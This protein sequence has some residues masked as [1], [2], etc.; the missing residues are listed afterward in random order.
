MSK[1]RTILVGTALAGS[2]AA[3]LAAAPAQAATAG[4]ATSAEQV[5]GPKKHFFGPYYSKFG[6]GESFGK[7]S[8]FKGYWYKDDGR[9]WFFGDLFDRDRDREY[10]YVW[11]KWHDRFGHHVKYYKTFG[12][13]HFDK[14]GGFKGSNGFDDFK[15]RVCEGDNR[16]DDCGSWGDAF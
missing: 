1:F 13:K 11:F 14:F 9:Y 4:T 8:Y 3:G 6:G 15:I 2:L 12:G 10:S 7:R 16:F 5:Q